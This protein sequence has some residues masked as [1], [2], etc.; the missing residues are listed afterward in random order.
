MVV[1]VSTNL[2]YTLATDAGMAHIQGGVIA[3]HYK[4]ADLYAFR[5]IKPKGQTIARSLGLPDLTS[6][7]VTPE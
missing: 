3:P 4:D 5:P 1:A 2:S 7:Q 6:R